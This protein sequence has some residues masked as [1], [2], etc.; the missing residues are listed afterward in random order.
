MKI[1]SRS[2]TITVGRPCNL[3]IFSKNEVITS[4]TVNGWLKV[5]KLAYLVNLSTTTNMTSL[6]F[7]LGSPSTKSM[8]MCVQAIFGTGRGANNPG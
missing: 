2:V 8:E 7:D 1:L 4:R 6:L 3:N 5:K